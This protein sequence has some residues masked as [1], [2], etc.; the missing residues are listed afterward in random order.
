[1]LQF[2]PIFEKQSL[3]VDIG[4]GS[5]EFVVG[6]RGEVLCGVS[7][8]LGHVTLTQEFMGHGKINEMRRHIRSVIRQSGLVEELDKHGFEVIIGSSGTIRAIEKAIYNGYG[9][10]SNLINDLNLVEGYKRDWKFSRE[11]LSDLVERLCL[12]EEMEWKVERETIFKKRSEFIV[13]GAVLLE[14]IFDM[15][16]IKM[17]EVSCHSLC[18]GVIAEKLDG[19]FEAYGLNANAR[20]CSVIGL[21]SRFNSK[22]KLR[23]SALCAAIAK[24]MFESVRKWNEVG[25]GGHTLGV[26]LDDKDLECLE[27]ACLLHSIGLITGKKGYHKQ[28]YHIIMNGGHLHGYDLQEIKI[29]AL[30]SRHHRKK[31]PKLDRQSLKGFTIEVKQKFRILCTILRVSIVIQQC[32]PVN[33]QEIKVTH[34]RKGFK[35]AL[36]EQSDQPLIRGNAHTL[37]VDAGGEIAK[38]LKIFSAVLHRKLTVLVRSCSSGSSK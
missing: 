26:S 36:G 30:L 13:A 38:E 2:H 14:E 9:K 29:I 5:T 11:N 16:R 8:Q 6:K 33:I 28:S 1:M 31:F 34:S 21:A 4:G 25:N 23:S 19:S 12:E 10:E 22:K 18:E 7:V 17:M 35:L 15:L 27:A 24:E 32:I 3:I 20:W 37:P